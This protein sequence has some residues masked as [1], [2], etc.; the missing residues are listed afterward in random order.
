[1]KSFPLVCG[2]FLTIFCD[3]ILRASLFFK[4]CPGACSQ[5]APASSRIWFVDI[6]AGQSPVN[7]EAM[8]PV[9]GFSYNREI[10]TSFWI[11]S[12]ADSFALY[13][14][15]LSDFQ[16]YSNFSFDSLGRQR[17]LSCQRG[18]SP[19]F[20]L[21]NKCGIHLFLYELTNK[22]LEHT[23]PVISEDSLH[24]HL[25]ICSEGLLVRSWSFAIFFKNLVQSPRQREVQHWVVDPGLRATHA[26]DG[27][28]IR[29]RKPPGIFIK[30]C[31]GIN[32]ETYQP[33]TG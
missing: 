7:H 5:T 3:D 20:L 18:D 27:S 23:P 13:L 32:W 19:T 8:I 16:K 12:F 10:K 30:P 29:A 11:H 6:C 17:P 24:N 33:L 25:G 22:P 9:Y 21:G 14:D 4:A 15:I 2:N 31:N 28:E 1:M 26:V